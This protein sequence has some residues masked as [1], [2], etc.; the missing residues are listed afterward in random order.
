MDRKTALVAVMWQPLFGLDPYKSY[1]RLWHEKAG[2]I[3]LEDLSDNEDV[4]FGREMESSRIAWWF[5]KKNNLVVQPH[6]SL[7]RNQ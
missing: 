5:G 2:N 4:E 7:I 3:E 1:W 6:T